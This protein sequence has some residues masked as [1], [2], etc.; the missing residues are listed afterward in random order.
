MICMPQNSILDKL[1]ICPNCQG[2]LLFSET[3]AECPLCNSSYDII[4]GK[5][6]FCEIPSTEV[7]RL[8]PKSPGKGSWWRRLNWDFV[9]EF[10]QEFSEEKIVLEIGC[11]RG[12]FKPLFKNYLG[13]DI[14]LRSATDFCCDLTK[15]N[16]IK[17]ESIDIILMNNLLEH[18]FEFD[19]LFNN[20]ISILKPNGFLLITVPCFSGIHYVP[21]D[22]WRYTN[23]GLI[24]LAQKYKLA[25][26]KLEAVCNP[27]GQIHKM[28][29]NTENRIL[30]KNIFIHLIIKLMK[31]LVQ[32][33]Q[34]VSFKNC[35]EF[36]RCEILNL[37][38]QHKQDAPQYAIGYHAVFQKKCKLEINV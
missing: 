17:K 22:Y 2:D 16:P 37:N 3:A 8:L 34:K 4:E 27:Y 24:K 14:N 5:P 25:P 15:S 35:S 23:F 13:T 28:I 26:V 20:A 12:Y 1:L 21:H 32:I 18:V 11:G 7:S 36:G 30:N 38:I 33:L 31:F 9:K 6:V 10:M 29:S 19:A